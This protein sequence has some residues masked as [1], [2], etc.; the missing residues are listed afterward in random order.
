MT[1][2]FAPDMLTEYLHSFGL[3]KMQKLFAE[4]GRLSAADLQ[5][6]DRWL[7][8][9]DRKSLRFCFHRLRSSAQVFGMRGFASLCGALEEEI[10]S[11]VELTAL[12][13]KIAAVK[14]TYQEEYA[15]AAACLKARG[16]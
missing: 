1:A 15:Q 14:I 13:F 16:E 3:A 7:G 9:G 11:G 10:L 2:D 5:Q 6:V 4:F 8:E 12:D